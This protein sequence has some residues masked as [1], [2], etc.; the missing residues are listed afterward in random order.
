MAYALYHVSAT[1]SPGTDNRATSN[2]AELAAKMTPALMDAALLLVSE[3]NKSRNM[4]ASLDAYASKPTV[5][6][7]PSVTVK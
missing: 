1:M 2:R 7:V 4:L 6:E 3:I 5:S